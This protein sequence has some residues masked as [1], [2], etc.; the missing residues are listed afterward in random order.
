MGCCITHC[1][2]DI[3]IVKGVFD[4]FKKKGGS[5]LMYDCTRSC[6]RQMGKVQGCMGISEHPCFV[7]AASRESACDSLM[8]L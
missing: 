1:G 2:V 8:Y 6:G 7:Q 3:L 4:G 5:D